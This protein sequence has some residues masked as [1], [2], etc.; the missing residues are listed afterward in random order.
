MALGLPG[1]AQA[2]TCYDVEIIPAVDADNDQTSWYAI[3]DSGDMAGNYC[4][5]DDCAFGWDSIVGG[6]VYDAAT[7]EA[8]TFS[9]PDGYNIIQMAALNESGLVVGCAI[10]GNGAGGIAGAAAFIYADGGASLLPDPIGSGYYAATDINARGT[11]AGYSKCVD[12]TCDRIGWVLDKRGN[13]AEVRVPGAA[14]TFAF[15]INDRGDV[16]GYYL[17]GTF[18]FNGAFFLPKGGE[19]EILTTVDIFF[20]DFVEVYVYGMDNEG[21]LV[22]QYIDYVNEEM[23]GFVWP[24]W[25]E[26]ERVDV[27]GFWDASFTGINES[28]AIS[29]TAGGGSVGL[30]L[31]PTECE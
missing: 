30:F 14:R 8:E 17:D 27:P 31:A 22:G 9:A 2:Q 29:G 24:R 5:A 19:L 6:A 23:G 18:G 4:A 15:A 11:I 3:N 1:A 10:A 26:M 21:T 13:H 28:G 16:A 7:G 12:G 20:T 25:G